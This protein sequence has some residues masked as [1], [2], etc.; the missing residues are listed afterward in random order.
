M[1]GD[2]D[3]NEVFL[4]AEE[5]FAGLPSRPVKP[6]KPR[7]EHPQTGP[8]RVTV[9][10]VAKL[11]Y[12]MLGYKAPSL[13][14]AEQE[15]EPYAL[16]VLASVLD[17]G[18]SARLSKHLVREKELVTGAGAGY[19]IFA[20]YPTLFLFDATP[21]QEN[22]IED[23]EQALYAEIQD[24][25]ENLVSEKE[26]KR[27]KAQVIANEVYQQDS[28]QRQA[29]VIG[30]LETVGLSW[31]LIGEYNE[32]INAITAEQVQEVAQKYLVEDGLTVAL[33][34]PIDPRTINHQL[35]T[36]KLEMYTRKMTMKNKLAV[37]C[38]IIFFV[39]SSAVA[40]PNIEQWQTKNG[41]KTLFV[42]APELAMVDIAITFDAGSSRDNDL[43]GLSQLTHSM[44]NTGTGELNA[45]AIAEKFE[46]LGAQ[47]GA[48]VSL[49]RSSVSFRSLTDQELFNPALA[50]F[51]D[52]ISKPSFPEK[53]FARI[54][55]QALIAIKDSSQRPGDMARR[56][57]YKAIYQN[58]PYA[59]PSIG[60]KESIEAITLYD[61]KKF[62]QQ[63][64]VSN[65][66]LIAIVGGIDKIQAKNIAEQISSSLIQGEKA[67][68]LPKPEM[69]HDVKDIYIPFPS[70]QSHVYL[71]H[72][73]I[74]RGHPD[75]FTLYTG[76]HIL[77]GGGFYF[78][79]C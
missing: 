45:D 71:G 38:L 19:N 35:S 32:R 66:A 67:T 59:H 30:S 10:A 47:F 79:T 54:K 33:L 13:A 29:T 58:H 25:K 76:N 9:K 28:I 40:A 7:L 21:T 69:V 56:A 68:A 43:N 6:S 42:A 73:G 44:L 49:D 34:E 78:S 27:V 18:R 1:V 39:S 8:K 46:E 24:L 17:G 16:S 37:L 61:V 14:T 65:N 75:Y 52:I 50:T 26:L 31:K 23:A 55:N 20:R 22:T 51:I 77:G 2:V 70:Q 48:S 72:L 11:P 4:M 5:Y 63:Y 57:F 12:L 36:S 15:W 74:Q 60:Y 64:L 53:D 3:P 62:H 41:V